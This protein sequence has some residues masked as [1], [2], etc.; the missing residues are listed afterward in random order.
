MQSYN[1]RGDYHIKCKRRFLLFPKQQTTWFSVS[2]LLGEPE[3]LAAETA[4]AKPATGTT[5]PA[6]DVECSFE[7]E[8]ER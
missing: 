5:G 3:L 7:A 8:G 4:A 2:N 6:R 1:D